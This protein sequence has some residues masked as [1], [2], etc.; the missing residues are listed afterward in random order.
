MDDPKLSAFTKPLSL[1]ERADLV[2][3]VHEDYDFVF[4]FSI[5]IKDRK[6]KKLMDFPPEIGTWSVSH[7]HLDEESSLLDCRDL[8]DKE[9]VDASNPLLVKHFAAGMAKCMNP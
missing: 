4:G 7:N 2:P 3:L 1:E 6:T 5:E 9:V 8:I